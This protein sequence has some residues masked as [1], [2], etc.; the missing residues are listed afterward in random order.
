MQSKKRETNTD[1]YLPIYTAY[2][3]AFLLTLQTILA[4]SVGAYWFRC[5]KGVGHEGDTTLERRVRRHGNMTEYA[6]IFLIVLAVFELVAGQTGS[7]FWFATLFAT[8]RILHVFGFSSPVG[9]HIVNPKDGPIF[10]IAR[11]SGA[12][13]T[14]VVSLA[15]A[16][17]LFWHLATKL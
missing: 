16:A 2:L 8:A 13:L 3:G 6:P 9:S 1:L 4:A 11:M 14:L 17:L 7:I 10:I 5:R 15:L 12:M